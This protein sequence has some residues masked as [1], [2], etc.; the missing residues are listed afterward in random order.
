MAAGSGKDPARQ[1]ALVLAFGRKTKEPNEV[2][3]DAGVG[4]GY[5]AAAEE[6]FEAQRGGN[7]EAYAESLKDF[8]KMLLSELDVPIKGD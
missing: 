4:A 2:E 1:A 7:A 5:V 3:S 8:V 6:L